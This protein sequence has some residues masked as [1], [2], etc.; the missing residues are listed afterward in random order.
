MAGVM[1]DVLLAA[2][3][4]QWLRNRVPRYRFV[5]RTVSRFM[6]G[7]ELSDALRA[8]RVLEDNGLGT[9]FT[10]LG[11][12]VT[13][14]S[15]A[16]SVTRHYLEVLDRVEWL[17]L[18]TEVS[19]KLTQLGL[20]LGPEVCHANLKR[21]I[22]HA[23]ANSVVWIDMEASNYVDATLE[24]YRRARQAYPN[25]GICLQAYL[26]RTTNDLASLIPLGS[27]IRLV[28]G[29]YK[30][31]ADVAFPRK[32][33]VDE[34]F[35]ALTQQ[36]VSDEARRAGVQTAIATHDLKLIRRIAGLAQSR[37]L[38]KDS[39]Q[40]QMLYGIQRAGQLR[41]ANDGWRSTV[42]IAYGSY[43]FPWFMRRLAERPANVWFL[44]RNLF[45]G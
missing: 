6:P 36:L 16:E 24:L 31:P 9:V 10:R 33:D 15:E 22:Q 29:A 18:R 34:N 32:R 44:A 13:D 12:N 11:E 21:I 1:R 17:G 42:L 3:Q 38:G 26:Y 37:G 30:E 8:A 2:S 23:G 45:A 41:L 14:A 20:D 7:E 40:F 5:R 25:V 39:F 19:V 4:N 35:L 27:A 28:K 43:W